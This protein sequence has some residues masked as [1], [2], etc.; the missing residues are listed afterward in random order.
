M[1]E[2]AAHLSAGGVLA[3]KDLKMLPWLA[4]NIKM[5]YMVI[6]KTLKICRQ[7]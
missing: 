4:L 7:H 5:V 6:L 3:A 2:Y 1:W